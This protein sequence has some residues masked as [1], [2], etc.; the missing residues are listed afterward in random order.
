[1]VKEKLDLEKGLRKIIKDYPSLKEIRI[2]NVMT[3][4]SAKITL[5]PDFS[6]AQDNGTHYSMTELQTPKKQLETVPDNR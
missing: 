1:M 3:D 4:F 5:P 2:P 6:F